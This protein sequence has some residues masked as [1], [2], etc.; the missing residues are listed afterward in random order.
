MKCLA[1]TSWPEAAR[2][3]P[4]ESVALQGSVSV[5][6]LWSGR[7]MAARQ[8]CRRH[9]VQ[10]VVAWH[11]RLARRHYWCAAESL[12]WAR[13]V[14]EI[15]PSLIRAPSYGAAQCA[16]IALDGCRLAPSRELI[17]WRDCHRRLS[18]VV[19]SYVEILEFILESTTYL[20]HIRTE[21]K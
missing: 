4:A 21:H 14:A 13:A 6:A 9:C 15:A 20:M 18:L 19:A 3:W 2:W 1:V 16:G 5:G 12:A 7:A 17:V 8:S 11:W 10:L